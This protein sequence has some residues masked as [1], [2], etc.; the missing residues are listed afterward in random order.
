MTQMI[1]T[2]LLEAVARHGRLYADA[3]GLAA[4]PIPALKIFRVPATEGVTHAIARPLVCLVVQ[5]GKQVT[6]GAH[7][8]EFGAGE[9]LLIAADVPIVSQITRATHAEPYLSLVLE[10]DPAVIAE[11]VGEM[12]SLPSVD[13]APLRVE[14]TDAEVADA[15]LRL[16]RLLDRPASVPVLQGPL[17]REMHY[18]LLM[19]RHG[20][21]IRR[22][23]WPDS[24][25]RRIGRAVALLRAQFAQPIGVERLAAEAGMSVS[26]FHHHFRAVTSLTPLQFHKQLRLIEARRLMA[27]D[28]LTAG[29]A[30]FAVGY[31]SVPHFTRDYGRLF[32][33]PPG[34]DRRLARDAVRAA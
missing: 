16:M 33:R 29:R 1:D 2:S 21:A 6:Q 28:G 5:G 27:A 20:P 3:D 11:L 19:G 7:S 26:S 31:E 15:A 34:R 18:W 13:G 9:T 4:T 17:I 30:A 22:L 25:A 24:H 10:L 14:A 12:A 8:H 23:G 32:G